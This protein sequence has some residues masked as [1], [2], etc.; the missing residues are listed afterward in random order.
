MLYNSMVATDGWI[1]CVTD[2]FL[3][4]A[5]AGVRLESCVRL[6]KCTNN[7]LTWPEEL[8]RVVRVLILS[9]PS[10]WANAGCVE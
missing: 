3:V 10:K 7:Y 5:A 6:R 2:G 9:V 8:M 4:R 1:F